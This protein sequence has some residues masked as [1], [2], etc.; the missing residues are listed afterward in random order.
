MSE[1]PNVSSWPSDGLEYLSHCPICASTARKLLHEGLVDHLFNTPGRWNL[2]E[3]GKCG[4][5]YLDPR[6]NRQ[7]IHLAYENYYTHGGQLDDDP[8]RPGT[9]WRSSVK[10]AILRAYIRTRFGKFPRRPGDALATIMWLR[11]WLRRR[12]D[13]AMR[14][15][16]T[17]RLGS[18]VVLDI[19]CG[20]GRFLSW[21][22][23]AG[24]KGVGTEFDP[25]AASVTRAK[26]FEV[27][28]GSLES[29]AEA[30]RLFDAI[31]VSHVIEHVHEPRELLAAARRLLKP[32]G[33]FWIE[34]PNIHAHGHDSFG[35]GWGGLHPPHHLQ[36]FTQN[37]L[38]DLMKDAGFVGI[39]SLPWQPNWGAMASLSRTPDSATPGANAKPRG[40]RIADELVSYRD[41]G[42]SEFVTLTATVL[43]TSPPVAR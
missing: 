30:G 36:V 42:K 22:R 8:E 41:P 23:L 6:P 25:K 24:W 26:G 11:P 16:P 14:H 38:E 9:D 28:E 43:E 5:G 39:R 20:N 3:C 18:D 7:T 35:S 12:F 33:F 10:Q 40:F 27:W 31:T 15:L 1:E 32:G 29:L 4:T 17:P 13:G 19:G 2:F 34:T 21:A 37:A